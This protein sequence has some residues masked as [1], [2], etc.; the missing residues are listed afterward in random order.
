MHVRTVRMIL[1]LFHVFLQQNHYNRKLESKKHVHRE[2]G[3]KIAPKRNSYCIFS[4]AVCFIDR[5][6][7]RRLQGLP[8]ANFN[9]KTYRNFIFYERRGLMPKMSQKRKKEL[10][11]FLNDAG[12]VEHNVLCRRCVHVCVLMIP[13]KPLNFRKPRIQVNYDFAI[14]SLIVINLFKNDL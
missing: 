2:K 8:Q 13:T 1:S 12:R 9:P 10:S 14:G 7:V 6:P 3:P 11:L 4:V 5:P